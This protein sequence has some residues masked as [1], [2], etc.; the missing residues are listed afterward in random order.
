MQYFQKQWDCEKEAEPQWV[1]SLRKNDVIDYRYPYLTKGGDMIVLK[2]S[3][4]NI[5]AFYLVNQQGKERKIANRAISFEDYYSFKNDQV[6][7]TSYEPDKRWGNSE[8]NTIQLLNIQNGATR[9]ILT[10]SKYYSPDISMDGNRIAAVEMDPI[11]GAS[12]VLLDS[13][14]NRLQQ[15]HQQGWVLASPKFASNDASVYFT[16]RNDAGEMSL[17]HKKWDSTASPVTILPFSNQL[18]GYLNIQGDTLLYTMSNNSRDEIWAL[19]DKGSQYENYRMASYATGLYQAVLLNNGTKIVGSAFT[20]DG[21]RLANFTAKW[22][23]NASKGALT[24]LYLPQLY[25][26]SDQSLLHTIRDTNIVAEKYRASNGLVKFH[27]WRPYY[28]NPEYSFT[29]YSDNVLNTFHSELSYTYNQNESSHK[30]GV[31]GIY[32]GT[33]LQPMMGWDQFWSR[34]GYY[35]G[36]TLLH[37][38]ESNAYLGLQL[39]LNLTSGNSF[40]YL[41]LASTYHFDQLKWTGIGEKLFQ[42]QQFN[43][44]QSRV[45][46]INQVQQAKQQIYPHWGQRL[47]LQYKTLVGHQSATQLLVAGSF[48]LPG[49]SNNHSIVVSAAYQQRDTLQQYLFSNGFPFSRGY[50]AVDFPSMWKLGLNYH[51]PIAYPEWGLGNLIYIARVRANAFTTIHRVKP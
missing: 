50:Y 2:K 36:D 18:I 7:Y 35:H 22:E 48:Y 46:Y 43:A 49:F 32:G 27:S 45:D 4:Q 11:K 30:L 47:N 9:K 29:M 44:I 20:A 37:W 51:L 42:N 6:I 25:K 12:L 1:S 23:L 17:L 19:I 39:P 40:R 41:T 38:N 34:S 33:Y 28:S 15:F 14:G 31:S 5:S 8:Y 3:L 16:A 21:Y 10:H 13:V 24:N 26:S